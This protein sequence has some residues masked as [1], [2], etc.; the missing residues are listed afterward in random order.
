MLNPNTFIETLQKH[1]INFF[2]GIPD[3]LLKSICAYLQDNISAENNI[4]TANEGA[5]VGLASGYYLSTGEIPLV[6]MQNS[7]LGNI[8][9]PLLSLTD[10]EVYNIPFLMLIGWRGEPNVKDEPQHV[11]QGKI[12]IPLLETLCVKNEILSQEQSNFELQLKKALSHISATKEPF[13]FIVRKNTFEEYQLKKTKQNNNLMNREEAIKL[14]VDSIEKDAVIVS[15]TGMIS[16][17]LYEY[18]ESRNEGHEKDFLTVGSMGHASQIAFGIALQNK[19]RKI[20]CFD[21]DGSVLM[22]MGAI[23]VIASLK[24]HNFTHIV[25]NNGAHDSVG[26]QP[27]VGFNIQF[28]E[29]ALSCG[30]NYAYSVSTQ[31]ALRKVLIALK[32][33]KGTVFIEIKVKKGARKNLGRPKNTPVENKIAFM[34]FLKE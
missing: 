29:L 27:T 19:K 24:P 23:P 2:T 8:V 14:T 3:S 20:Y 17:E 34:N 32:E 31:D 5:A 18:R 6:Y 22:H 9:N 1:D 30:Y 11:K 33:K 28:P 21:G 7:G 16:R 13:A 25:F 26:G 15:T 4:I 10:K 12:T